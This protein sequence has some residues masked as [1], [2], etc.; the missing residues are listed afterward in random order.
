MA[1]LAT[2]TGSDLSGLQRVVRVLAD[3][4]LVEVSGA[5]AER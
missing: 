4:G 5:T 1:D 3:L 2:A